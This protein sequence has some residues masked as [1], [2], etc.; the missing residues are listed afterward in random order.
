MEQ[1]LFGDE[2][3]SLDEVIATPTTQQPVD[4][5]AD[6][7]F[8]EISE[9]EIKTPT[10]AQVPEAATDEEMEEAPVQEEE[11]DTSDIRLTFPSYRYPLYG[12]S[13]VSSQVKLV[14]GISVQE[15]KYEADALDAEN[16]ISALGT[17]R[18]GYRKVK[19]KKK[20][21]S[22]TKLLQW[23]DGSWSMQIGKELFDMHISEDGQKTW[24]AVKDEDY[25]STLYQIEHKY[26]MTP[27]DLNS[28]LLMLQRAQ[29]R[30]L[31]ARG[32]RA[33][34][35]LVEVDPE[36]A[37]RE[38][39]QLELEK[40]RL[41]RKL[42]RKR[43]KLD[44]GDHYNDDTIEAFEAD[45][46]EEEEDYYGEGDDFVV[47]DDHVDEMEGFAEELEAGAEVE[48]T[49]EPQPDPKAKS[50]IVFSSDDE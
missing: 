2:D 38:A 41:Q 3:L 13:A 7:L 22:N 36:Q 21:Q 40:E 26:K 46:S 48:E 15:T 50:N 11:E 28:P 30:K 19:G 37:A 12:T 20:M 33:K 35:I 8:G 4:N 14:N 5:L 29:R 32:S 44:A 45:Y 1:D 17:I 25:Y 23:E 10:V 49:A 16:D 42:E 34:E 43:Q 18:W 24:L 31:I 27:T 47:D 39:E 6:Q 9:E